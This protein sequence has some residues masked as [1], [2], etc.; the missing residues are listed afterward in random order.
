MKPILIICTAALLLFS[1]L[2]SNGQTGTVKGRVVDAENKSPLAFANVFIDRTTIGTAADGD[3]YFILK[4]VPPGDT[5]LLF[6]FVGYRLGRRVVHVVNDT[7]VGVVELE[8]LEQ[9]LS[10]LE[11]KATRDKD[12]EKQFKRF[13]KIFLGDDELA[14]GCKILNPWVLDFGKE[15][16]KQLTATAGAPLQIHNNALGYKIDFYLA[17]FWKN[18]QGYL[19]E[20]KV[21][22]EQLPLADSTT[23]L[24]WLQNRE[25]AYVGSVQHLFRAIISNRV[26][27]EKFFLY[28]ERPGIGPVTTRSPFF[29]EALET[30][31]VTY[32][33]ASMLADQMDNG[34]YQIKL[35]GRIEV[36]NQNERAIP[37][38]Y[39]DMGYKVSWIQVT[40]ES[41]MV[42][43]E[44]FPLNPAEILLSGDVGDQR[45]SYMLPTDYAPGV[46]QYQP[47]PDQQLTDRFREKVFVHT[48][49][50]YYHPG[51][52]LWFS[53]FMNYGDRIVMDSMSRVLYVE[54]IAPNRKIINNRTALI[55]DG[56]AH[57]DFILPETP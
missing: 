29:A 51:E 42:N 50:P 7:D 3:G 10:N 5:E 37:R 13:E 14:R 12:W 57:G 16:G 47:T 45:V 2:E 25:K 35:K 6:S 11:I 20:G 21:R 30:V 18:S 32:D 33:T 8:V 41:V 19:I 34:N 27:G 39:R 15:K 28:T 40:G 43:Q 31:L 48:D 23:T 38:V 52:P 53:A 46:I 26:G 24:R 1:C 55:E 22:F 4:G 54:L 56:A 36:H 44:G 17:N 9:Q 49:K